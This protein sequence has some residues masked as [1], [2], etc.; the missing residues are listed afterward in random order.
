MSLSLLKEDLN[1]R[2]RLPFKK[3]GDKYKGKDYSAKFIAEDKYEVTVQ[4]TNLFYPGA[5]GSLGGLTATP[6]Y[7]GISAGAATSHSSINNT[8]T[9]D[10]KT[11]AQV[12][13][14]MNLPYIGLFRIT[15]E[16]EAKLAELKKEL[17]QHK[18]LKK[19]ELFKSLPANIRQSI[20]DD[21]TIEDFSNT[22]ESKANGD[23]FEGL[24][25]IKRLE[26]MRPMT[27]Q[28]GI[29]FSAA[30]M[31]ID[32]MHVKYGKILQHLSK[33]EIIAAHL[34]K[35]LEDEISN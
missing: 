23:D 4:N 30:T 3:I 33:D 7:M 25:E 11:M 28:Y 35:T 9:I 26:A 32:H 21:M 34:E 20:V 5:I 6:I 15:K 8:H 24:A 13:T 19:I 12:Y 22:L 2:W 10:A 14:S 18:K 29:S 1:K 27:Y 17:E 31:Y 16:D